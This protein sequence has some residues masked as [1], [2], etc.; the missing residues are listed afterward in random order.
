MAARKRARTRYASKGPEI[1][2]Q[3]VLKR[4]AKTAEREA[5]KAKKEIDL[6]LK[7]LQRALQRLLTH[8]HK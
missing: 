4:T 7:N 5:L 3:A 8:I 6:H 2:T 1:S